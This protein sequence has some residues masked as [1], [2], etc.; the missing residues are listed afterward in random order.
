M[1]WERN[2]LLCSDLTTRPR[3][4][5]GTI[6][7]TGA[8][9][10]I[11]G[12]LVTE[13]LAR[14]YKV[15]VM[16]RV[17]TG[18]CQNRW[19]EAETVV[20]DALKKDQLKPALSGVHTA[21]YLIHP[22]FIGYKKY[23]TTDFNAAKNFREVA[24]AAGIKRIILLS[25][26]IDQTSLNDSMQS[27]I[28]QIPQEFKK[29][30]VP[31]TQ[32]R[33]ATIIGSGSAFYELLNNL[34]KKSR[35]IL[36]PKW[37][38]N[39]VQPVSLRSLMH[40]LVGV[41]E[42]EDDI[43]NEYD[44][45]GDEVLT[46]EEMFKVFSELLNKKKIYIRTFISYPKF[47]SYFA[48]LVTPLPESIIRSMIIRGRFEMICQNKPDHIKSFYVPLKFRDSILRA[49]SKEEHDEV[50]TRW[51]DEYP[52]EHELAVKL[53]DLKTKPRFVSSYSML[54]DESKEELFRSFCK[55]GGEEGWLRNNWMWKL[56]GLLDRLLLGVGISRGRRSATTLR[57]ND[58]IDFWR[59]EEIVETSKF[60]LRAEMKLPGR[61]WLEFMVT[62]ENRKRK[63]TTTAYY[64]TKGLWGNLYWYT[65][66][67]FHHVIFTNL[68]K[69]IEIKSIQEQGS[70]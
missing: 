51:S 22:S 34:I 40:V 42:T 12:R 68:L 3:P 2:N 10:Y 49:M 18:E 15:R 28:S 32:L 59:V 50:V 69:Q 7:V 8:T 6:L 39:K 36:L 64:Q 45:C 4:E 5:L 57:L 66:L 43:G 54:T 14:G 60:L 63:L 31:V 27:K 30:I 52:R 23:R 55:I 29:S 9:G 62:D 25:T 19:P 38:K 47:Y 65:F 67:P 48:S 13:L 41:L 70:S 20:A 1:S 33:V 61:A 44:V 37:S 56:R 11:G 53:S 46:Y 16:A 17:D 21:Y 26:I 35:L 24:D 58:V